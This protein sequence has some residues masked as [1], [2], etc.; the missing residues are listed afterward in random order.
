[1]PESV[2]YI[3]IGG[4]ISLVGVLLLIYKINDQTKP[5]NEFGQ[6]ASY[7]LWILSIFLIIAGIIMIAKNT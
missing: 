4:G 3:V 6:A 7:Q 1:M 2:F 5:D